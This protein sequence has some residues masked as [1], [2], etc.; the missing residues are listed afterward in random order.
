MQKLQVAAQ[1]DGMNERS[2]TSLH[3]FLVRMP[4]QEEDRSSKRYT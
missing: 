4:Y 3:H 1:R 2:V